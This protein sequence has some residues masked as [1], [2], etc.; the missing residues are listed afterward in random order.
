MI[1]LLTVASELTEK[2]LWNP[3]IVGVL[4]VVSGIVLFCG[5]VYLLLATNIG[6]RLGFLVAAAALTGLMVLLSTVWL[7]TAT[8]LNSPRGRLPAWHAVEVVDDYGQ[9]SIDAVRTIR[10][11]GEQVGEA[12]FANIRP[13]V[14]AALVTPSGEAEAEPSEFAFTGDAADIILLESWT[15][16]GD[17]RFVFWHEPLYQTVTFCQDDTSDDPD[18][19]SL[20]VEP[21]PQC[22]PAAGN[23]IIVFERDL[24]SLRQPPFL[25][26]VAFGILFALSLLG[27]YWR[28][29]D[30]REAARTGASS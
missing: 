21:E 7:T 15:T 11:D 12:D 28:E 25:F 17:A 6:A 30:Q 13:A 9:S 20:E 18:P 19:S 1:A 2:T 27:L 24:G 14:D 22:D 3:T 8:P 16:G 23:R 26:L 10:D 5:S 4:V 29:K